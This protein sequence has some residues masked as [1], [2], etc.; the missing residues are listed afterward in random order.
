MPRNLERKGVKDASTEAVE[1]GVLC[2]AADPT[3]DS[4][5]ST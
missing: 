2:V 3:T 4:E 5:V 1:I